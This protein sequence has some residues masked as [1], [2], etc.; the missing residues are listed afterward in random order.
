MARHITAAAP[1]TVESS[2]FCATI[3]WLLVRRQRRVTTQA[4]RPPSPL[5]DLQRRV[6]DQHSPGTCSSASMSPKTGST[7]ICCRWARPSPSPVT[8]PAWS[9]WSRAWAKQRRPGRSRGNWQLRDHRRRSAEQRQAAARA[10][11][12]AAVPR[13]RPG[14]WPPGQHRRL[15]AQV[16]ALFAERIRPEPRRLADAQAQLLAELIARRRQIV[17]M[18]GA[19]SNRRRQAWDPTCS[20]PRPAPGVAHRRSPR[21]SATSTTPSVARPLGGRRRSAGLGP[22][23]RSGHRPHL[24]RRAARTRRPRP[25]PDRGP[26]RGRPDQPRQ[27]HLPGTTHGRRWPQQRP[28]GPVHGHAHRDPL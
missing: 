16:I 2:R 24:D 13:F 10:G 8:M 18:I 12:P 1:K 5:S 3:C 28:Q 4:L 23:R 26:G 21:L 27:R 17:E 25:A 9:G 22:R 6:K 19:E 20:G 11:Q 14:A 15:D 7:S